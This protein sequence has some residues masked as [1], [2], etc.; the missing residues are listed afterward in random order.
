[1]TS[2]MRVIPIEHHARRHEIDPYAGTEP[3]P[4]TIAELVEAVMDASDTEQEAV[5]TITYIL[6]SGHLRLATDVDQGTPARHVG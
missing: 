6:R 5:A 3:T 1:M 4:I 2:T